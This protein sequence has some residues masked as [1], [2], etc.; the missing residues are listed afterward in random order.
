MPGVTRE[1]DEPD[2]GALFRGA[3]PGLWRAIYAFTGGRRDIADDV[4]AE[5]FARAIAQGGRLRD[6]EAWIYRAAFRL[7]VDEVRRER[8][9]VAGDPPDAGVEPPEVVEVMSALRRLSPGQRAAVVLRYVADLDVPEVAH[10]MGV[11][12]ATVRV[13]LHRARKRLRE[14]LGE[15][16]DA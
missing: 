11:T 10:R 4:V 5:A 16:P 14:L 1:G 2:L 3:G 12:Q 7:A 9:Q 15:Q 13:Q 6:L 8:R